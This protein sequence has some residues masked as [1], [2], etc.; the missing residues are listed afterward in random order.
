[1]K[2]RC[3]CSA[4]LKHCHLLCGRFPHQTGIQTAR[5]YTDNTVVLD[6]IEGIGLRPQE[7]Y[8]YLFG[9]NAKGSIML[10]LIPSKGFEF[11][12]KFDEFDSIKKIISK[13][14]FSFRDGTFHL[15]CEEI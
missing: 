9:Y 5:W 7:Y 12:M 10:P 3:L 15:G 8:V 2:C 11:R 1:M 6:D 14:E 4:C 13:I